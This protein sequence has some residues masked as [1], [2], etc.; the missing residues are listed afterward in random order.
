MDVLGTNIGMDAQLADAYFDV[1]RAASNDT[2]PSV[3]KAAI[4]ILWESCIG[5]PGFPR[6][7]EACVA[8][9]RRVADPED[10]IQELVSKVFH[11]LWFADVPSGAPARPCAAQRTLQRS[12]PHAR[13]SQTGQLLK[14]SGCVLCI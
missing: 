10:S 9:L 11:S 14:L 1:V 13:S 6:A 4:R 7:N 8:V 5:A 12:G 3:R 2:F